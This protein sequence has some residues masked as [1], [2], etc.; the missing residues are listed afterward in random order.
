MK[1]RFIL[2]ILLVIPFLQSC[3]NEDDVAGIFTGK[4]WKM[5]G[6]YDSRDMKNPY[7][8]YW[9]NEDSFNASMAKLNQSGNFIIAFGGMKVDDVIS[10]EYVGRATSTDYSGNW[11][12]NGDNNSFSTSKQ[13]GSDNDVLGQAFLAGLKDAYKY[14]GDYNNLRIH[15]K[16]GNDDM[17]ILFHVVN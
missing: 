1:I 12:A 9:S 3:D 17:F 5:T 8:G 14:D 13:T 4:T 11:W 6:I 2:L 15:F 10:G 16:R 7:K